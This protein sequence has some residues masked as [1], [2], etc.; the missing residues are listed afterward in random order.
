M[1]KKG[2]GSDFNIEFL[3]KG[4]SLFTERRARVTTSVF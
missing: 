2:L 4:F 3:I 1:N